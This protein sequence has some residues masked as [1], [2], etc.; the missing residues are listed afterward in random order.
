M[1]LKGKDMTPQELQDNIKQAMKNHDNLIRD[2]YRLVLNE[3]KNIEV[4]ERREVTEQDVNAMIKRVLKQTQETLDASVQ[5]DNLDRT[6]ELQEKVKILQNA[7]PAQLEGMVLYDRL[8]EII[9]NIPDVSKKSIGQIMKQLTQ[10]TNGNFD[11]AAAGQYLNRN[12]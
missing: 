9:V 7:L 3:V 8:Q 6:L 4:N 2:T 12:L 5:L 1:L 11:K 10:E